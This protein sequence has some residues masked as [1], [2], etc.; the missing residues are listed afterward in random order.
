MSFTNYLENKV[1]DHVFNGVT[2]TPPATWYAVLFTVA[3]TNPEAGLAGATESSAGRVAVSFGAAAS[4]AVENDATV[5][6]ASVTDTIVGFGLVDAA[7]AGNLCSYTAVS[8]SVT[9]SAEPVSIAV[10]ALIQTLD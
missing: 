4:G 3:P 1:L 10:G 5:D 7:S 6:W 9:Y 8:P 2:Y